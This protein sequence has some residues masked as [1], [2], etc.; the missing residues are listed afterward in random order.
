MGTRSTCSNW[1][2]LALVGL[3]G[4]S[5]AACATVERPSGHG[6]MRPYQVGGVWYR[7]A[8]QPGYDEKGLASWYGP[9]SAHRTTADG[10]RF[11]AH[12]ASA[13]HKTLPLPC[14]VEVT[15]LD[16]GRVAHLRV[17]DR[18][19]FVR[20]RILDVS[21]RGAEEL[22]FL[23]K[24]MAHVRVRYVG[25]ASGSAWT[26]PENTTPAYEPPPAPVVTVAETEPQPDAPAPVA[27]P[28]GA[29]VQA[30]AYGDHANAERAAARLSGR[31][32][33]YVEEGQGRNGPLWRVMVSAPDGV[34]AED[35]REEVASDG[36]A[37][38]KIVR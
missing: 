12:V 18:G 11:D 36:F 24:G 34:S 26:P 32:V 38:A 29:R 17:N 28:P 6:T 4:A 8:Y 19:P 13:A 15:N 10:E 7:P 31:G 22:G 9:E 30:G 16:N 33:A 37:G 35:L 14:I 5:L 27:T 1:P 21:R 3:A 2:R 20:G 25:P 23:G